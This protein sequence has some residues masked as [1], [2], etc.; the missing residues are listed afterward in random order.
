MKAL[1]FAIITHGII[2]CGERHKHVNENTVLLVRHVKSKLYQ[3]FTYLLEG[4]QGRYKHPIVRQQITTTIGINS[5]F[6]Y[7]KIVKHLRGFLDY[8]PTNFT[9][10]LSCVDERSKREQ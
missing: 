4:P 10:G 6:P 5:H 8:Q 7:V 9:T 1:P 3:L 2:D